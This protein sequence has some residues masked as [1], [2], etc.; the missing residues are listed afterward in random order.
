MT[1]RSRVTA[2]AWLGHPATLTAI[3]VLLVNDHLLK[4]LWPGVVTGKLSDVA[5]MLVAPPLLA[6]V[7]T[8]AVRRPAA[9]AQD[10]AAAPGE[11]GRRAALAA[12]ALTGAVFALVKTTPV[13]ARAAAD[14]W[15]LFTPSAGVVA[16]PTDLLALPALGLAWVVRRHAVRP[17]SLPGRSARRA[18]LLV[19]LPAAVFAVTATAAAPIPP[20]ALHV[21]AHDA[22]I[23]VYLGYGPDGLATSDQGRS[24]HRWT[25]PPSE[26][27]S[28]TSCVPGEPRRC[29]RVAPPLL[30]VEQSDDAGATWTT[31]WEISPS[32]QRYLNRIYAPYASSDTA[33]SV[34]VTVLPAPRG[35]LVAVANGRDGVALRD[36]S[37]RWHRLGLRG[38]DDLSEQA[39]T[40]L[41]DAGEHIEAETGTAYLTALTV[42][43]AALAF[44]GGWRRS[45]LGF[46]AAGY[47]T[48]GGLYMTVKGPPGIFGLP[49]TILGALLVMGGSVGLAAAVVYSS[50]RGLSSIIAAPLT[51]AAIYLPFRGWSAG[52]PDDYGTAVLLAVVL[53]C[54]AVA[55]GAHLAIRARGGY[56]RG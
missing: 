1:D 46:V 12:I 13:G 17:A 5:G 47:V 34:A 16:D 39:A 45:P 11:A 32:R 30:R 52:W 3:A 48:W 40:P 43:L 20:S 25:S 23:V 6:L 36:V 27:S 28:R 38:Y 2:G 4:R 56:R 22:V 37:G 21:E 24:W 8:L 29:Y 35:H 53:C 33:R 7:A 10:G 44:A 18:R 15:A 31:A 9:P 51:F 42:L 50:T 19:A 14:V 26:K 49:F 54:P 41:F 55:L